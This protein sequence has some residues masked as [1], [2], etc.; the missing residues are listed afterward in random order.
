MTQGFRERVNMVKKGWREGI[1]K[2]K[3]G[4]DIVEGERENSLKERERGG[5]G[6]GQIDRGN[7]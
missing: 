4:K 5:R 6:R 1:E 7:N 3:R 2:K